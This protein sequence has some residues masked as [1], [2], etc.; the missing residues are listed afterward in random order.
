M[1]TTKVEPAVDAEEG[2][3][4]TADDVPAPWKS[5]EVKAMTSGIKKQMMVWSLM[6]FAFVDLL[7]T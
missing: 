6:F 4:G 1:S 2:K 5:S 3:K 7:G